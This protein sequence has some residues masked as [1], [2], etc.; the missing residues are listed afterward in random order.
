MAAPVDADRV[1]TANGAAT[2]QSLNLPGSI[3][4]GDILVALVRAPAS[5]T[6]SWPA[7][8][9]EFIPDNSA[10]AS[11]D[12]TS[13]AY[14]IADGTEGAT[15]TVTFGT[16]RA[17]AGIC[18]R[19]TGGDTVSV[20]S[21]AT[22]ASTTPDPPNYA[23]FVGHDH[24]TLWIGLVGFDASSGQTVT[25]APTS[26]GNLGTTTSGGAGVAGAS[27]QTTA[28]SENPGTFTASASVTWTTWTVAVYTAQPRARLTAEPVEVAI[29]PDTAKAR[30]TAAPVEVGYTTEPPLR[31]SQLPVEV[32]VEPSDP[33]LR[34]SQASVEAV[35][36][37][38]AAPFRL[39]QL[40]VE[41]V[42][43]PA[44]PMG[45]VFRAYVID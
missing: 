18:Y 3:A 4:S 17:M 13:G 34:V 15:I 12:V 24:E 44:P 31:V 8:W 11:D 40:A 21:A 29:L 33:L 38:D 5:T 30:L 27:Q 28:S 7:G 39:S 41:V 6:I 25:A 14:R 35:V 16:S 22:G 20:S 37:P 32:L 42:I 19:I 1:T 23:P 2:S 26:Y 43:L 45:N 9:T 10:D 36:L